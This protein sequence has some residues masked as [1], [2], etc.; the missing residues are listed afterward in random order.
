VQ[1]GVAQW[2]AKA[3]AES[4]ARRALQQLLVEHYGVTI[5]EQWLN[6][7]G[8]DTALLLP[9]GSG[10]EENCGEGESVDREENGRAGGTGE[11]VLGEQVAAGVGRS[12]GAGGTER[13]GETGNSEQQRGG[14]LRFFGL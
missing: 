10:R 9:E 3:L 4:A 1:G 2:T 12:G 8:I 14:M 11:S 5:S 6:A 13:A 7:Q